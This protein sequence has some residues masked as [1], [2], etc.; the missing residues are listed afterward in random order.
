VV[1]AAGRTTQISVLSSVNGQG[2]ISTFAAGEETG[3]LDFRTGG[4]GS[5]TVDAAEAGALGASGA[6]IEMP[7]DA[8]A[9]GVLISGDAVRAAEWCADT[10]TTEAFL[11]G[12]STA[13]ANTFEFQ[14]LNPYAGEA[15]VQLTVTTDAGIESDERFDAV[16][17]PAL[18]TITLDMT[19]IIPGREDIS[20]DIEVT[21]GSALGV[22]RQGIE[23]RSALWW[24]VEPAQD[25]WMPIPEGEDVKQL[26]LA[27]PANSE[28]E[29]QIDYYGAEGLEESFQSGVLPGR[30]RL[31]VPL[32]S[33]STEAA[34]IRVIT[35]GP[36]VPTLWIDSSAGL[37]VTTAS[38]VDAPVWLLPGASAPAGG[39]GAIVILNG[40]LDE[41]SVDV[42]SLQETSLTRNF[43]VPSEGVIE[44]DLVAADGYRVEASGPI[45]ALWTSQLAGTGTAA[46]GIPI[47]DG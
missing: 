10:P 7:S 32:A 36:V 45:V 15:S 16:V 26:L 41:V 12:G 17:V 19:E 29:Y 13:G 27:S 1:A 24:A 9:S 31:R 4:S 42:R 43:T 5:V 3:S 23:G 35:T 39:G 18:S 11:S 22:G 44:V 33:I 6:L 28:I 34:G 20:V 40:G 30:G 46:M 37:A 8:T 14:L 21:E 2:R 25:W 38:T 47:Q